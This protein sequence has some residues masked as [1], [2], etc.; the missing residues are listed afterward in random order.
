M[1]HAILLPAS[2]YD[3]ADAVLHQHGVPVLSEPG[4]KRGYT[5]RPP[6][7]YEER[8][9]AQRTQPKAAKLGKTYR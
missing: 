5:M 1:E 6:R 3:Y 2:Q 4:G 9:P 8:R 7:D